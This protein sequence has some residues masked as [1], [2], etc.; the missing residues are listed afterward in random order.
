MSD[1]M[2][3]AP[4]RVNPRRIG[5]HDRNLD[6][7]FRLPHLVAVAD[8]LLLTPQRFAVQAAAMI[9]D[10]RNL[11][12]LVL[13]AGNGGSAATA[14]HFAADLGRSC[15]VRAIAL[16]DSVESITGEANDNSYAEVF[17]EQYLRL[18]GEHPERALVVLL[19]VSGTSPSIA[20][21]ASAAHDSTVIVLFGG[22]Q[23]A[24]DN[25]AMWGAA[26]VCVPSEDYEVVE[27]VHLALCHA[28]KKELMR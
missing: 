28:I 11:G 6:V 14:S 12:W 23:A 24:R 8:A 16:T 1:Y 20:R 5:P 19:S 4:I 27:D 15:G 9:E 17:S 18:V 22:G 25:A 7:P 21:L 10:A 26:G 2:P 13:V 3:D